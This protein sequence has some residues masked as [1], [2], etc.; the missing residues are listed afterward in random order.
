MA[1]LE[2]TVPENSQNIEGVVTIQAPLARVFEAYTDPDLLVRWWG[3]GNPM[4]VYEYDCRSG[5]AWHIA[6]LTEDGTEHAFTGSV[7]EVA[8]NERIIQTFEY[9]G[10][11][12]RGHVALERAD[13]RSVGN[14]TTEIR[15]LSTFQSAADRDG[16]VA[17]G[18]ETG[19]RQSIEAL[20]KLI[21]A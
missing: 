2:V 3:R 19:W 20:G 18:M 15:T 4:K 16:M 8:P 6:E 10:M 13:F 14:G 1:E 17:S 5:G 7:H 12:E 21:E 9:L 11:P